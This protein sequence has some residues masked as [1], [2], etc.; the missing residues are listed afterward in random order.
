MS[1]QPTLIYEFGDYRLDVIERMLQ[2]NGE[3]V[4]LQPK[5]F[6]LLLALV[7]AARAFA[8]QG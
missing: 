1:H 5:M 6:D 7:D 3:P 4:L 8:G 2:R